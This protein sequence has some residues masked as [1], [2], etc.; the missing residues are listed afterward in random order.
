MWAAF[1]IGDH[2][3]YLGMWIGPGDIDKS[4]ETPIRKFKERVAFV[5]RIGGGIWIPASLSLL[6]PLGSEVC[7]PIAR[8]F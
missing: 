5:S 2:G 1:S 3:K 8:P 4:W 7:K 6:L